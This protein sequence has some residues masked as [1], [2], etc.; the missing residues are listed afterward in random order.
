MSAVIV[1]RYPGAIWDMSDAAKKTVQMFRNGDTCAGDAAKYR[2]GYIEFVCDENEVHGAVK[3]VAE[4]NN[5]EETGYR[6]EIPTMFACEEITG[7]TP[8]PTP[9]PTPTPVPVVDNPNAPTP[10]VPLPPTPSE[11]QVCKVNERD[12]SLRY[13]FV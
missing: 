3:V 5:C 11:E 9:G 12:R 8:V 6:F 13:G 4:A 10:P 1:A 7:P 2:T